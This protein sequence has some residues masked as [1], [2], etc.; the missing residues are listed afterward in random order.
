[1]FIVH[2]TLRLQMS[3]LM[4]DSIVEPCYLGTQAYI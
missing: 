2:F 3:R 4:S 1:M